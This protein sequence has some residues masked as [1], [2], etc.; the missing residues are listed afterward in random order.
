MGSCEGLVALRRAKEVDARP[1]AEVHV[2][3]WRRA[4]A[5][6]IPAELLNALDV[7]RRSEFWGRVIATTPVDRRPWVAVVD[8]EVVGFVSAGE[9]HDDAAPS[10]T[11]EIYAIYVSADC[12]DRGMGRNLMAH[13]ERDLREHGYHDATLWVL[14]G[15]ERARTFYENAGWRTDGTARTET[16]G[17]A[18]LPE[19]RY[20]RALG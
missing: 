5:G 19:V 18:E 11:G 15:N 14:A 6:L 20:H 16:M 10:T 17:G 7:N 12:W 2:G 3:T 4:Y 8:G 13:A 9:S 1:I